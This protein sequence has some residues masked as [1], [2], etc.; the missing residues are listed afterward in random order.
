MT[1]GQNIVALMG[2]EIIIRCP[3]KAEPAATIMWSG[4]L[5]FELQQRDVVELDDGKS[6]K[7]PKVTKV[8]NGVYKCIASNVFGSDFAVTRITVAGKTIF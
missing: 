1:I 8:S 4:E 5:G 7:I 3:L 2:A 6:L